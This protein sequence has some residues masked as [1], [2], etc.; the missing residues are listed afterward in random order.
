MIHLGG[1]NKLEQN[2]AFIFKLELNFLDYL[3]ILNT[4]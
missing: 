1:R 3:L 4:F 2:V